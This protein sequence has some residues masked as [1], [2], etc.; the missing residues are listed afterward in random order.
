MATLAMVLDVNEYLK[1]TENQVISI[2]RGESRTQNGIEQRLQW[3]FA[4][5]QD[6]EVNGVSTLVILLAAQFPKQWHQAVY[7]GDRTEQSLQVAITIIRRAI[8]N[9]LV[10]TGFRAIEMELFKYLHD[11]HQGSMWY[12]VN[13]SNEGNDN[14]EVFMWELTMVQINA[15]TAALSL[16][17]YVDE[18]IKNYCTIMGV[19]LGTDPRLRLRPSSM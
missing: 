2:I 6:V 10:V 17:M 7:A 19:P 4:K 1:D 11:H 13:I 14:F 3:T 9:E 5:S 15:L 12:G 8:G 16:N 18:I